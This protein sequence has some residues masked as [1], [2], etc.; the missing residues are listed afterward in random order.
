MTIQTAERACGW[1]VGEGS[2]LGTG[3][4]TDVLGVEGNGAILED[5]A[6]DAD[7]TDSPCFGKGGVR[8]A[9]VEELL[10]IMNMCPDI[11]HL[12]SGVSNYLPLNIF[13]VGTGVHDVHFD[14]CSAKIQNK[15]N[16]QEIMRARR[17]I[18]RR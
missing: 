4:E 12:K 7:I 5:V 9:Q 18:L 14:H 2:V 13:A 3:S 16:L 15:W 6:G 1:G 10:E 11:N 17:E 8:V